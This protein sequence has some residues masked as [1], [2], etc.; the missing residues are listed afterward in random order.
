MTPRNE[1]QP[2]RRLV[3]PTEPKPFAITVS[4]R[5]VR[6]LSR[7]VGVVAVPFLAW[8]SRRRRRKQRRH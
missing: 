8:L 2:Q 6:W 3:M 1:Y 5:E 4:G 7:L